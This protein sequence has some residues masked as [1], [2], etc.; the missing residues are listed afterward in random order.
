MPWPY[1][2]TNLSEAQKYQRRYLLDWY[3]SL[4]QISVILPLLVIQCYFCSRWVSRRWRRNAE[5][6]VPSSPRAKRERAGGYSYA[7]SLK[8]NARKIAWWAGDSAD[9]RDYHLGSKGEVLG[10]ILWAAWL[11][12]LCFLQTGDGKLV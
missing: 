7:R 4:A 1:H 12:L 5:L 6:E 2:F 8:T 10:A 9:V 3:G 11:L